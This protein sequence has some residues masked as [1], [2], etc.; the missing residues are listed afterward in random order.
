MSQARARIR[1]LSVHDLM[2]HVVKIDILT[3]QEEI[4]TLHFIQKIIFH[5]ISI[6][7]SM[8]FLKTCTDN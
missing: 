7:K 8:H 4:G 3:G 5:C 1:K 6:E 2:T